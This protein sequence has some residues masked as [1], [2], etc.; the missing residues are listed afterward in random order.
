MP[1]HRPS[2]LP[3]AIP[4]LAFC[5]TL[6]A[7]PSLFDARLTAYGIVLSLL[8]TL[9][10]PSAATR[11]QMARVLIAML[12][13]LWAGARELD[14]VRESETLSRSI[15]P[16]RFVTIDLTATRS[17]ASASDGRS[18]LTTHSFLVRQNSL[19]AQIEAPLIVMV[20]GMPPQFA[21]SRNLHAEGF[22]TLHEGKWFLRVKS[23][24]LLTMSGTARPLDP[25]FWNR[26]L[27]EALDRVRAPALQ[28]P[29]ALARALAL[30]QSDRLPKSMRQSYLDGGTYHLLV[31]SGLQIGFFAAAFLFA[32]RVIRVPRVGDASLLV[33]A[34]LAP[35]FAGNE[36]SVTRA[37]LMI[38]A[39]A[40]ARL[41][42]RP[43]ARAN[44]LFVAAM[45]R[46]FLVPSELYD[47]GFA[48]TFSATAGLAI[49]GPALARLCRFRAGT[50]RS[51]ASGLAAEIGVLPFTIHFFQRYVVGGWVVTMLVSPLIVLMVGLSFAIV[52]AALLAPSF[53]PPLASALQHCDVI[54]REVNGLVAL[55]PSLSGAVLP[56]PAAVLIACFA[57]AVVLVA[58]RSALTRSVALLIILVPTAGAIAHT[59]GIPLV[60]GPS[61]SM[62]D[63]GQGDASLV[64][65]GRT[66]ILVDG[67][68]ARNFDS[69]GDRVLVPALLR[70]GAR[71]IDVIVIS[72]P[73]PDHCG[74]LAATLRRLEV[75][76]VWM[77]GRHLR[78]PCALDVAEA[79]RMRDVPVVILEKHERRMTGSIETTVILPR[80]RYK[81]SPLNNG[82][83]VL[84]VRAASMTALF[85][86]DIEKDAEFVLVDD[87]VIPR[88]QILKVAH[89]GSRTSSSD[90]LLDAVRPDVALVSCGADNAYGHPDPEVL[91]RLRARR[92]R[93]L[94]SDRGGS[95]TVT[96]G[97]ESGVRRFD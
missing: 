54:C 66:A 40:M 30:G 72:H 39:W 33:I 47:A 95:A 68:G 62:I 13:G 26:T 83:V 14:R 69:F 58:F 63:V 10:L 16:D 77:S 23:P 90:G 32:A 43:T 36:P 50:L 8:L 81:R 91:D 18:K 34:A 70:L 41:F 28:E 84:H 17:W 37:S 53:V 24:R 67:G 64:S 88:A 78:E 35:V 2:S 49:T 85:T 55:A 76:E 3:A 7:T 12:C 19:T 48:L 79:A 1:E 89:H 86:G 45:L 61:V 21:S 51:A 20:S 15:D 4:A 82:S 80:L 52:F 60:A 22:L 65:D 42:A 74:G 31:F 5:A 27:S 46:L 96:S 44:L 57:G 97:Y 75:G 73:H 87:A 93:I 59:R 6:A 94:R 92:I 38:G 25:R 56:V 11:G 9:S 71:R 29:L